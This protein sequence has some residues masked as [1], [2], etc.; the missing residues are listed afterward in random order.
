MSEGRIS[1]TEKRALDKEVKPQTMA[2]PYE[3][4]AEAEAFAKQMQLSITISPYAE[5]PSGEFTITFEGNED[6]AKEFMRRMD[7]K[8]K[9]AI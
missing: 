2:F 9:P 4:K 5:N 6:T 3:R 7:G 8:P 1:Y